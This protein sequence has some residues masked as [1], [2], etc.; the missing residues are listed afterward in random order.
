MKRTLG[1]SWTFT[2]A[3]WCGAALVLGLLRTEGAIAQPISLAASRGAVSLTVFVAEDKGYFKSEGVDV[4]VRDCTSGRNCFQMLAEG[5]AD[6]ATAAEL[7][8][9]LNSFTRPDL[10]I[11]GTLST[12]SHQIKLIARRSAGIGEPGQLRGKRI[13]TVAGT[14]AQYFLSTWL[15]FHDMEPQ[16]VTVVPLAPEH[17]S[18]ALQRREIDAIAV[19]EPIA[20]N[21]FA[22][23]G[24][25]AMAMPNPRVYTQHFSLVTTRGAMASEQ[26]RADFSRVIRAL[27]RAQRFI[28]KEPASAKQILTRRL[29]IEPAFAEVQFGEHDFRV[30]L[31]QT[32]VSTMSSQLR[33]AMRDGHVKSDAKPESPLRLVEPAMLREIAP[34]AVTL[35][36]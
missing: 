35:V 26:R 9:S 11:L 25:D 24:E 13:G 36:R 6:L 30:R 34:E 32:L 18:A 14:S 4:Q 21:A 1:I 31:D 16:S 8:V 5:K 15:L 12:S 7:V 20:S 23:L 28:A 33:W 22:A 19:W 17:L 2:R 10:V 27:I 29:N 3:L